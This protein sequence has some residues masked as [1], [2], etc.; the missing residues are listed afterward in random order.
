MSTKELELAVKDLPAAEF[1]TFAAWFE[2]YLADRW[3]EELERD[4]AAGR[5]DALATKARQDYQEGRCTPL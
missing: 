3:D 2:E 4:I 5:L 1:A